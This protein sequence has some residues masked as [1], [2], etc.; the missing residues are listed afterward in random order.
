MLV[1]IRTFKNNVSGLRNFKLRIM[2][3]AISKRLP[4]A[5][6]GRCDFAVS[7]SLIEP[8]KSL[9]RFC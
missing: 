5:V 1:L 2:W 9:E 6:L 3:S 7:S 8:F 4:T